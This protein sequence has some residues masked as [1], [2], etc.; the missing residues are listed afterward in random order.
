[1]KKIYVAKYRA[2]ICL[3][4]IASLLMFKH[5]NLS[6]QTKTADYVVFG[7]WSSSAGVNAV[8]LS[9]SVFTGN[10]FI[11]SA[12]SIRTT[13]SLNLTGS[14]FSAEKITLSNNNTISGRVSAARTSLSTANPILQAG[15]S[16]RISGNVDI[17][18]NIVIG[19]SG[20]SIT[21]AVTGASLTGITKAITPWIS[22]NS[23]ILPAQPDINTALPGINLSSSPN[24]TGTQTL[25]PATTPG[26]GMYN[27]MTL[28]GN[29]TVT[30]SGVGTY[31]INSIKNSGNSNT[32]VFDFKNA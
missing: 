23:P 2:I 21:G 27:N 15:T 30:F 31:Y 24:I 20:S 17:N 13:G 19:T 6:A 25:T 7:G 26:T 10:G 4:F 28:T 8:D 18:G 12:Q 32:F 9:G 22:A 11:G 16:T 3:S 29:R 5:S 14:I 1:M